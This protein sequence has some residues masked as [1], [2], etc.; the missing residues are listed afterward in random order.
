MHIDAQEHHAKR[1]FKKDGSCS[2]MP[3]FCSGIHSEIRS[4]FPNGNGSFPNACGFGLAVPT[5]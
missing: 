2:E 4:Q 1:P 5:Y 3:G